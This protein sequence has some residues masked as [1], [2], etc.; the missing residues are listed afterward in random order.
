MFA[1]FAKDM[2]YD[3]STLIKNP[4]F[5]LVAAFT[6]ALGIGANV[7]VFTLV[8]RILLSPL[9]FNKPDRIVRM[10]HAYPEKGLNTWGISP[11]TFAAHRQGHHSF[12]ALAVY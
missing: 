8:E 11:A 7:V 10:I 9:P 3:F 12:D 2:R 1:D 4:V 6:I 5:S